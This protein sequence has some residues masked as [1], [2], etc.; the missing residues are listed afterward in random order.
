M[1]ILFLFDKIII[2]GCMNTKKIGYLLLTLSL[3][4]IISGCFSTFLSGL[5]K[6]KENTLNMMKIVDDEFE[7]FSANTSIFEDYRENLYAEVLESIVCNQL[8]I[9]DITIKNKL[10][11]YENLV[12][13]L[14]KSVN[15]LNKLCDD[16][17]YPS[18]LTNNK[19]SN[20]KSIYE[21]VNN[22]FVGDIGIYNR[23]VN[24]CKSVFVDSV[25][26]TEYKIKRDYIDFNLDNKFDGK[27]E[28]S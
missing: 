4:L 17:Y 9:N 23:N 6:D 20:Y 2:G 5:R 28:Q 22:Y 21:Q 12:D 26:L 1:T 11:N 25:N 8:V 24:T 14:E 13:E 18:G 7:I 3:I 27:E 16:V 10:S 15:E 19:C